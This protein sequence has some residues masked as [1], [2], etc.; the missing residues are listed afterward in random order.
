M[1]SNNAT[2]SLEKNTKKY[3]K[4]IKIKMDV[5]DSINDVIDWLIGRKKVEGVVRPQMPI[6]GQAPELMGV[7]LA[8]TGRTSL[9]PSPRTGSPFGSP[10]GRGT[11]H[12]V[13]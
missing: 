3:P 8:S 5:I 4:I 10:S 12:P 6:Y 7:V 2:S 13:G 1:T 9:W 11:G